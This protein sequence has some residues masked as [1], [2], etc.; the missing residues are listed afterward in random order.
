MS[1]F[2]S[3]KLSIIR[4]LAVTPVP[5]GDHSVTVP[6]FPGCHGPFRDS[7]LAITLVTL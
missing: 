4:S 3:M 7:H 6:L 5:S 1:L 2:Q